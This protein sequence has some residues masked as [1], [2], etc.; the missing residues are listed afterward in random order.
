MDE[1]GAL[2]II[3]SLSEVGD[4]ALTTAH[5]VKFHEFRI[6]AVVTKLCEDSADI[7]IDT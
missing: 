3:E 7:G 1:D 5:D 4:E 6:I 2:R